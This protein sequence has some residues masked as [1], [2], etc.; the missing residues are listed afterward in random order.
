M[1]GAPRSSSPISE[2]KHGVPVYLNKSLEETGTYLLHP[3]SLLESKYEASPK[4]DSPVEVVALVESLDLGIPYRLQSLGGGRWEIEVEEGQRFAEPSDEFARGIYEGP[5]ADPVKNA[6]RLTR[7]VNFAID[8]LDGRLRPEAGGSRNWRMAPMAEYV[9]GGRALVVGPG[10]SW[11]EVRSLRQRLPGLGSIDIVEPSHQNVLALLHSAI[12]DP[13]DTEG[14]EAIRHQRLQD[15]ASAWPVGRFRLIYSMG[16]ITLGALWG[17]S[18]DVG[19]EIRAA[20]PV[21]ARMLAPRG[22][23]I[24][25]IHTA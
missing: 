18:M 9:A 23:L 7:L 10:P 6:E 1:P 25:R 8:S 3:D 22:Y 4:A 14:V 13:S 24:G 15:L 19:A 5:N 21:F 17:T 11:A 20:W 16:A 12:D 2:E